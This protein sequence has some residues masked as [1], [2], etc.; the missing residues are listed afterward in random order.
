[1]S[2]Y[3]GNCGTEL[4]DDAVVCTNCGMNV[5]PANNVTESQKNV[6][7]N[8]TP[9]EKIAAYTKE[10]SV[11]FIDKM[12]SDKKFFGIVAGVAAGVVVLIVALI[13]ISNLGGY[14]NAIEKY[15]DATYFGD[16]DAYI[17]SIPDEYLD[18][19][20]KLSGMS[21]KEFKE[22]FE[23]AYESVLK[24][25]KT[26]YGDDYS[27]DFEVVDEFKLEGDDYDELLDELKLLGIVK[28]SVSEA[29]EIE[30][31][32]TIDGSERKETVD[33]DFIAVKI[34]GDWYLQ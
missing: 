27:V 2:K 11:W 31:E 32:F 18:S 13:F 8:L 29:Y 34:D 19:M 22:N 12:K 10:K 23:N 7:K 28:K 6:D 1:M 25:Y 21:E 14:N 4:M 33:K 9:A 5:A 20:L 15:V 24:T 16:A 3:C 30:V 26:K 17:D